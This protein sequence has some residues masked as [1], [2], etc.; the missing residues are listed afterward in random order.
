MY[1]RYVPQPD[2]TYRRSAQ[3][4]NT[5]QQAQ[6]QNQN[7]HPYKKQPVEENRPAMDRKRYRQ[8]SGQRRCPSP[9]S[10]PPKPEPCPEYPK[11]D[12]GN[13]LSFLRRLLPKEF[14]TG[15]LM[16]VLLILLM[17]ADCREEQNSAL[18]TLILYLF[19]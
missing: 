4:D 7:P 5:A 17:A 9:P 18:L 19:L 1:N 6:K 15:D 2:G 8:N 14:D 11:P 10:P 13:V 16:V 3:H 12:D